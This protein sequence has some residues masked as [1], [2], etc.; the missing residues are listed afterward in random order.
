MLNMV[1]YSLKYILIQN[2]LNGFSLMIAASAACTDAKGQ[3]L[4]GILK[5]V[6]TL[7]ASTTN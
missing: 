4:I 6:K 1:V 3:W 2:Q 7:V 5:F